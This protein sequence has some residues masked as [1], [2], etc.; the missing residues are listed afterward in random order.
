MTPLL[1]ATEVFPIAPGT[2]RPLWFIIPILV[3]LLGVGALLFFS[4]AGARNARFEVS[5]EGLRLRG[6]LY[7][8]LIPAADL[9]GGASRIVDLRQAPDLAP[10]LRTMGTALPGYSA[11]WFRL[12]NGEKALLYVTNPSRVVYLPTRAGYSVLVSAA[13]PEGLIA[14]LRRVAPQE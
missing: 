4:L 5:A 2:A 7:G 11:G 3:L 9:R 12:R 6:D 1:A 10:R 14:S 8:R 13:D